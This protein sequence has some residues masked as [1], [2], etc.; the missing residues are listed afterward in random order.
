MG[1]AALLIPLIPPMIEGL[2][3]VIKA[4]RSDPATTPEQKAVVA[5]QLKRL[6]V[7]LDATVQDVLDAPD[8]K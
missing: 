3:A 6:G 7:E 1:V 5:A 2:T 8:V 4:V